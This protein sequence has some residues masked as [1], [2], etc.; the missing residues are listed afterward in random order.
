MAA[1]ALIWLAFG[2]VWLMSFYSLA[3]AGRTTAAA[4]AG[5]IWFVVL[6][7]LAGRL[8]F[9]AGTGRF[10]VLSLY[11]GGHLVY[12]L[13]SLAGWNLGRKRRWRRKVKLFFRRCVAALPGRNRLRS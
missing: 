5:S 4:I 6:I 8:L 9:A 3:R 1:V 12:G 11:F 2:T 7:W 10:V 13:C